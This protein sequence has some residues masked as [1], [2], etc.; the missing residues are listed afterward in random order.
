MWSTNVA[1][2]VRQLVSRYWGR[3]APVVLLLWSSAA[4]AQVPGALPSGWQESV[5]DEVVM[6]SNAQ[7]TVVITYN[8][9]ADTRPGDIART[10][11]QGGACLGLSSALPAVILDGRANIWTTEKGVGC[12][13]LSGQAAQRRATVLVMGAK[14]G[15]A[16]VM[17]I[18]TDRLLGMLGPSADAAHSVV[19]RGKPAA[20][21]AGDVEAQ[22]KRAV[23]AVPAESR[24]IG[25]VTYGT[26]SYSGWPPSYSYTVTARMLFGNGLTTTCSDWDPGQFAPRQ[27]QPPFISDDCGLIAWRKAAGAVQ[28]QSE[29]R[30]WS[31]ADIADDVFGFNAGERIDIDFGNV[32]G[33]GFNF[34]TPGGIATSTLSGGTLRMTRDGWIA[35]GEWS[36]TVISSS[37]VAGESS[38]T[39]GPKVGRYYLDGHI[40]AIIDEHGQITRGFIAAVAGDD[41]KRI[42]HVYLNGR[43]Y[44]EQSE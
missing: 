21:A 37:N 11:D 4:Q 12:W 27:G 13:L 3:A 20:V 31:S 38:R 16:Q 19:S 44:W 14:A 1:G 8:K 36:T 26:G 41:G 43:H 22:L 17:R 28:F 6:L 33:I 42:G 32:G 40:I 7:R 2:S 5:K 35:V 23:A 10:M 25:A 29:D 30:S 18:A 15:D 39:S 34:G 24:P 9:T